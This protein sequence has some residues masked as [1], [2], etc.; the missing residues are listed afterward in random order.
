MD[1]LNRFFIN[2]GFCYFDG[3]LTFFAIRRKMRLLSEN[4]F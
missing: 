4:K 2:R 3:L 1:L